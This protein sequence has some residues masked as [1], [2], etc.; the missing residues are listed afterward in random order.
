[1]SIANALLRPV[2]SPFL[3]SLTPKSS[4]PGSAGI[5]KR[6]PRVRRLY[7]RR[8]PSFIGSSTLSL[9]LS[10]FPRPRTLRGIL[11]PRICS[12]YLLFSMLVPGSA[13]VPPPPFF[14]LVFR[15]R[16]VPRCLFCARHPSD[17]FSR[18]FAGVS[19]QELSL[20]C[21]CMSCVP[22]LT[23]L[24]W[25]FTGIYIVFQRFHRDSKSV[26]QVTR[27]ISPIPNRFYDDS[28]SQTRS[29][30]ISFPWSGYSKTISPLAAINNGRITRTE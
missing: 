27:S 6:G 9:S 25:T 24:L 7:K 4:R 13:F 16:H 10:L 30:A 22:R 18:F 8:G 23:D 28:I 1:M 2:I 12:F 17:E 19:E 14:P 21:D 26:E 3:W 5:R 20:R 11:L 29:F 15:Q